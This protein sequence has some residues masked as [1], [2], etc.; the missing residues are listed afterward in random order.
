MPAGVVLPVIPG[1]EPWIQLVPPSTEVAKP[2]SEEP[3]PNTRPTW[4]ADTIVEPELNVSGSTSVRCWA[5]ASVNGSVLTEVSGTF[6][7]AAPPVNNST[8]H[9]AAGMARAAVRGDR[10]WGGHLPSPSSREDIFS[11]PY[12]GP[13]TPGTAWSVL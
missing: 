7:Y 11:R 10:R 8:A 1:R 12:K 9:T 6:A 2:M 4:N 13:T 5:C 3:P